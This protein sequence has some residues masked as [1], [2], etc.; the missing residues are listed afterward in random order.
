VRRKVIVIGG[1][2]AGMSAAHELALRDDFDVVVYELRSIPGGKARSM[3]AKPGTAARAPLP[4]EH[5]FRFFPGFYRHVTDTMSRIPFAGQAAGVLDNLVTATEVQIAREGGRNELVTPAH[6]PVTE[7][8]WRATLRFATEYAFHVGIP[9]AEQIYFIDLLSDLMSACEERRFE[10]YENQ[11]W[12]ELSGA[13]HRSAGYQKFLADGLTRSLVAARAREMSARTGGYILLQLLQD[14]AKPRGQVDRVLKGPTNEMWIDPWLQELQRLG[15]DYRLSHRIEAIA[16]RGGRVTGV[17]GHEHSASGEPGAAFEDHADYYVA[18]VP[19]EVLREEIAMDDLKR[20]SPALAAL[21][22]LVVRW[23]NGIMFYL[24]QDVPLI[25]GHTIYI[26]SPWALTSISQRQFWPSVN[27]RSLGDGGVGGILSVD[28]SDWDTPGAHTARGKTART[29]TPRDVAA[30]SWEQLKAALNDRTEVLVDS[31]LAD[32]FLDPA[33]VPPNPTEAMNLEPLLVNTAG[34]WAARP[35]A[36]LPEVENLFLASDY[37]RT[38]TDL[39]TMEGAN[40]AARRAVNAILDAS[41]SDADRCDVWPL[42][43]PGGLPFQAARAADRVIYKL[44]GSR[45]SPPHTATL[46]QGLI[47]AAGREAPASAGRDPRFP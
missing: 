7:S 2:V 23:M 37:V 21:D 46:A 22:R 25:H 18:A 31:N 14:M 29:C 24:K 34:S 38:F 3:P 36:E 28:I 45:R 5:G 12:W 16:S 35:E 47:R 44:F 42:S 27:L 19:V 41:G 11:S 43:E 6:F 10:Q 13:E 30:E 39:A 15:V 32:W 1:G 8:D 4:G 33:I 17:S 20:A 40:E 26:D 9:V